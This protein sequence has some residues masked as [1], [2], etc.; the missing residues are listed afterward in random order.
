MGRK[1]KHITLDQATDLKVY[2]APPSTNTYKAVGHWDL[3]S[4]I[5]NKAKEIGFEHMRDKLEV[6]HFGNRAFGNIQFHMDDP[7]LPFSVAFR[8]TYDR[9]A[10]LGI[11]TGASVFI[12]SNLMISGSDT[13][14]MKAHKGT[15]QQDLDRLIADA[16]AAGRKN[17]QSK[18]EWREVLKETGVSERQGKY[19]LAMANADGALN[20]L[21]HTSALEHWTDAPFSEFQG[22]RSLWG[23]YNAMTWGA[24]RVRP[25]AKLEAHKSIVDFMEM[26]KVEDGNLLV[27]A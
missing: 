7:T 15:I 24:H 14:I 13:T 2:Q 23:V 19:L 11:A 26:V 4:R 20:K 6:T 5:M 8:S 1:T 12:C 9:S 16:F 3:Y 22:D 25:D 18:L 10:S 21:A 27:G 17:Y